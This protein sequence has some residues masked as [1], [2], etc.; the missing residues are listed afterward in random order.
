MYLIFLYLD[1]D[2]LYLLGENVTGDNNNNLESIYNVSGGAIRTKNITDVAL[3][4]LIINNCTATY[5]GG[6]ANFTKSVKSNIY[7][8]RMYV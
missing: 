5:G 3:Q 8:F 6:F 1:A 4:N 2:S 7:N